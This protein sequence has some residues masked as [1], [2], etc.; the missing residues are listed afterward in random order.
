MKKSMLTAVT[1]VYVVFLIVA[2]VVFGLMTPLIVLGHRLSSGRKIGDSLRFLNWLYGLYLVRLSRPLLRISSCGV[3]NIP[4]NSSCVI[5]VNHRS[6]ADIFFAP[7][8]TPGNTVV[9]VR[10]W[11]FRLWVLSWF[12]KLAGYVDI[13]K[14]DIRDFVAGPGKKLLNRGAGF[15]FF[16]EGHR[17]R[18]GRL[19]VFR[20][21]AF[22]LAAELNIPVIPVCLTGTE[23]FLP[24]RDHRVRP[25]TVNVH[26]LSPVHPGQ[27]PAERRAA[28]LKKHV[29][30]VIREQLDGESTA[31]CRVSDAEY[32][33]RSAG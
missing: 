19:Q 25:A 8:F 11:P 7:F 18:D 32:V 21:G 1:S 26:I 3:E 27:F 23:K 13:E 12:M 5:V 6:T 17:S 29:E 15:L 20:S 2:T 28:K 9:F 22:V 10:S 33:V 16:P 4:R 24:M 31:E 30:A 14:T